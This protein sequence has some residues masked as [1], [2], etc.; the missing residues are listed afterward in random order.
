M[1]VSGVSYNTPNFQA[2]LKVNKSGLQNLA[3]DLIGSS[4]IGSRTSASASSA[5]AEVTAFPADVAS[6]GKCLLPHMRSNMDAISNETKAISGRNIRTSQSE[7]DNPQRLKE[8]STY[9]ASATTGTASVA[10]GVGSYG[11]SGASAL[12][13]SVNYPMLWSN[14]DSYNSIAELG[15]AKS[16]GIMHDAEDWAYYNLYNERG[17]GNESAS[18][19]ATLWS[20][21][22]AFMQTIGSALIRGKKAAGEILD[23]SI[24]S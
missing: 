10:S 2:R 24:P 11:M 19:S 8:V 6:K 21:M 12:D 3:K 14:Q 7:F 18:S 22:G 15:G 13:Q 20:G 17:I 5:V 23:K 16:A 4:E 9:S 1:Q